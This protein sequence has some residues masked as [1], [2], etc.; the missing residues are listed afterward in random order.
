MAERLLKR[1]TR[2]ERGEDGW[3]GT[4][5]LLERFYP[6][7]FAKPEVQISLQNTYNQTV[8]ALSISISADEVKQIEAVAEP[9]RQSVKALYAAY[10]PNQGNGDQNASPSVSLS[11][12]EKFANYRPGGR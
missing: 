7:R 10:R 8:N 12:Q 3:V 6:S 11:V 9:V 5:W 2:I 1:L 4:A